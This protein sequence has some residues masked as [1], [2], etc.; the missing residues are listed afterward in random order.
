MSETDDELMI[1]FQHRR[2]FAAFEQL[3]LR[4]KDV[5]L[6]FLVRLVRTRASAEDASQH[7]WLKVIEVARKGAY[8]LG[9]GAAFRTW[10]FAMARNHVIDEHHRKLAATHTVLLSDSCNN[11]AWHCV[12]E[13]NGASPDPAVEVGRGELI[14]RIQHALARLPFEQREVIALWISGIDPMDIAS[15]TNAPRETVL[16]RK[17]YAIAKLRKSLHAVLASERQHD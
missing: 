6:R 16:S 7:T 4:H 13:V 1:R 12:P 5:L 9:Q 10:L 3:F 11:E 14:E 2:D 17:K 8:A 15:M